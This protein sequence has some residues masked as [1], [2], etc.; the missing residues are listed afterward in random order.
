M[1]LEA[2]DV[3]LSVPFGIGGV[4]SDRDASLGIDEFER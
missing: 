4:L 3:F 2:D 1:N